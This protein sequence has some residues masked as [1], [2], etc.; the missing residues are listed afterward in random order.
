MHIFWSTLSDG[1]GLPRNFL[2]SHVEICNN[3]TQHVRVE[4]QNFKELKFFNCIISAT[5]INSLFQ[6]KLLIAQN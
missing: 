3:I 4:F 5:T 1:I 2:L 6:R